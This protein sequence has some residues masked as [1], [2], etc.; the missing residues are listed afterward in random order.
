[1]KARWCMLCFQL[2]SKKENLEQHRRTAKKHKNDPTIPSEAPVLPK[3]NAPKNKPQAKP[4]KPVKT[5]AASGVP[6][7]ASSKAVVPVEASQAP[8]AA[9]APK[10]TGTVKGE[11]KV[12][13]PVAKGQ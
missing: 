4:V 8:K 9:K 12:P 5:V 6:V 3:T 7:A 1:M 10:A 11:K 2:F 13:K